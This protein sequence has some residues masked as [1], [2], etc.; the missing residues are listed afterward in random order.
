MQVVNAHAKANKESLILIMSLAT[1]RYI[2][3]DILSELMCTTYLLIRFPLNP[4]IKKKRKGITEQHSVF[5][6][7]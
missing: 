4:E 5:Q 6:P 2:V 7:S 1:Y 3:S